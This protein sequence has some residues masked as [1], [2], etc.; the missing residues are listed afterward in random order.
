MK[1]VDT[2][3]LIIGCVTAA[4]GLVLLV[5]PRIPWLGNLPGDIQ[6]RG[7]STEFHFPVVTCIVV[8]IVLTIVLNVVLRVF[9]R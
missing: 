5:A 3:L 6:Y 7:K 4:I 9:R 1:S 8:S 2:L